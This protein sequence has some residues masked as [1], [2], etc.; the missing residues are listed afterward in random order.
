[1]EEEVEELEQD[2]RGRVADAVLV[3]TVVVQAEAARA[4]GENAE[5]GEAGPFAEEK[6][7]AGPF[8]HIY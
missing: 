1:M 8:A 5:T 2:G 4:G 3:V 6:P 7:A